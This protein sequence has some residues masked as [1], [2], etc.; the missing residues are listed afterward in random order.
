MSI[1]GPVSSPSTWTWDEM[2]QLPLSEY[3][4]NIHCVT[5]WSKLDVTVGGVSVDV[6]LDAASPL[7]AATHVMGTSTTGYMTNLPLE[8]VRNGQAWVVWSFEGRP[9]TREQGGPVSLRG[10][11]GASRASPSGTGR[12]Q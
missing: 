9:L 5:T 6:L 1:D 12:G 4:G 3:H 7:P 10:R 2:Q 8:H 11:I